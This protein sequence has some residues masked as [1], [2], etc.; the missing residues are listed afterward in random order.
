VLLVD[1]LGGLLEHG[2]G[3]G[4][5]ERLRGVEV[6]EELEFGGL[7]YGEVGRFLTLQDLVRVGGR[8]MVR[9]HRVRAIAQQAADF[10][11]LAVWEESW[12]S[13]VAGKVGD[14]SAKA[15]KNW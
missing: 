4:E 11:V 7:R 9:F 3:D 1:D 13:T 6:D 10:G 14:L 5:P 2:L 15:Q 12:Q 8:A